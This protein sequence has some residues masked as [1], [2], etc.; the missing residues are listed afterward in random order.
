[1]G[2]RGAH[3]THAADAT[4]RI[5]A[6]DKAGVG[7]QILSIATSGPYIS[8]EIGAIIG[9][10]AANDAYAEMVRLYPQRFKAFATLPFPHVD[11][12]LAEMTRA[13]DELGM[14]GVGVGDQDGRQ[15]AGRSVVR[16]GVRRVEPPR[17]R[18]VRPSD[19]TFVRFIAARDDRPHLAAGRTVRRHAA[20]LQLL[21]NGFVKRFPKIRRSCRISAAR[22][23]FSCTVSIINRGAS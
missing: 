22:Y 7:M 17:R 11:A 13:F 4:I 21:Q 18:A 14:I 15:V 19:R 2:R 16:S 10:R 20:A 6:M 8:N 5:E 1:M 3:P 9:A 12:A 23:R